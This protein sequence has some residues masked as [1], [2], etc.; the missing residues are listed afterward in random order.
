MDGT[1]ELTLPIFNTLDATLEIQVFDENGQIIDRQYA[2]PHLLTTDVVDWFSESISDLNKE[3]L[4]TSAV[5]TETEVKVKVPKGGKIKFTYN[6]P[7][8]KRNNLAEPLYDLLTEALSSDDASE[9]Q[10]KELKRII[11][12]SLSDEVIQPLIDALGVGSLESLARVDLQKIDF[13]QTKKALENI[14]DKIIEQ[15]KETISVDTGLKIAVGVALENLNSVKI[16]K[17]F[18]EGT[19]KF[20]NLLS[21]TINYTR[22]LSKY[23]QEIRH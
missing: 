22:D 14:S 6:S 11:R 1:T 8:A 23:D 2:D 10:E 13:A 16:A 20:L 4:E 21:G 3:G 19:T 15:L 12:D 17:D 7:Y 18:A 5:S 9:P